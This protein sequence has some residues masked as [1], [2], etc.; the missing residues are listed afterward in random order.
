[1]F[2]CAL[3]CS[4]LQLARVALLEH[5]AMSRFWVAL[6]AAAAIPAS[7]FGITVLTESF[8]VPGTGWYGYVDN[9]TRKL[10]GWEVLDDNDGEKA[11]LSDEIRH[12][13]SINFHERQAL[14]LNEGTGLQRTI[15]LVAGQTYQFSMWGYSNGKGEF[16]VDVTI[17]NFT[18]TL[19][20][21]VFTAV[22]GG[23]NEQVFNFTAAETGDVMLKIWNPDD[24][25]ADY[26][27]RTIDNLTITSVPDGGASLMLF[28]IGLTGLMLARKKFSR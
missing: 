4:N 3:I 14:V 11:Y 13:G 10:P 23:L 2:D 15:S 27:C 5:S 1:M 19:N 24:P 28:G 16:G 6:A 17:G 25:T 18:Q 9:T 7:S 26:K 8:E 22:V 21:L 12:G 20:F